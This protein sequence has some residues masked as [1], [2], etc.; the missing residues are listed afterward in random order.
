MRSRWFMV[1]F[2]LG[3]PFFIAPTGGAGDSSS[4]DESEAVL[5]AARL[6]TDNS[7]LLDFIR[8]RTLKNA[9]PNEI[10]ALIRQLGDGA[11]KVRQKASAELVAM[12]MAAKPYLS[13]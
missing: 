2:A 5:K 8:K 12:G 1:V 3:Y 7:S 9:E 4:K 13:Q 11:F 6:A 10:R